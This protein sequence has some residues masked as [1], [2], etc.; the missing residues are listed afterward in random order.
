MSSE[1]VR[2]TFGY[3]VITQEVKDMI[4]SLVSADNTLSDI[5][6]DLNFRSRSRTQAMKKVLGTCKPAYKTIR[7]DI[8]ERLRLLVKKNNAVE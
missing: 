1:S 2:V 8:V 6:Y 4:L 7:I 3:M 5:A